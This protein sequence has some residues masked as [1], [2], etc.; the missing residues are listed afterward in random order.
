MLHAESMLVLHEASG[1]SVLWSCHAFEATPSTRVPVLA[2]APQC[3]VMRCQCVCTFQHGLSILCNSATMTGLEEAEIW[4]WSHLVHALYCGSSLWEAQPICH[5]GWHPS[6][7]TWYKE[8][9][10]DNPEVTFFFFFNF[11]FLSV[12][13]WSPCKIPARHWLVWI[14]EKE[15]FLVL[16]R[17]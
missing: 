10:T 12:P 15:D 1:C 14:T 2:K 5:E 9:N 3:Q 8:A 4:Q 16:G 13:W 6:M 17:N 11:N 7:W